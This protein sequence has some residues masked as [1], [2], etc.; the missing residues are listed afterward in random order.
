MFD[1]KVFSLLVVLLIKSQTHGAPIENMLT[2]V[3]IFDRDPDT[4]TQELPD[5]TKRIKIP[6]ISENDAEALLGNLG[7][8][9]TESTD[10]F[11]VSTRFSFG[12]GISLEEMFRNYQRSVGLNETGKLDDDTK[13]SMAAPRC[14]TRNLAKRGDDSKWNKRLITYRIRDYPAG[15]SPTSVQNLLKRAFN[16]WSKV[17]NLD[18]L[19]TKEREA[20]IEVNFGGTS[21]SRRDRR[22]SFDSPTIM[23]HAY[24]PE[25]GDLHFNSKYFFDNVEYLEDFLDTAMHEIGHSL[26]LEHTNTKGALM[27]PTDMNRYTKP[28]PDDVRRIQKLYGARRGGRAIEDNAAPRLCTVKKYD[29]IVDD[30]SGEWFILSGKYY[31]QPE[32]SNPTGK[33]ISS[34]WPGLTGDIDAAFRY[35]DGRTYFFKGDRFWRYRGSRLEVGYP[36]K[37]S[38]GFPGLPNSIDAAFVDSKSKIFAVKHNTYWVY[39]SDADSTPSFRISSLG[40]PSNVDAAINTGKSFIAFKGKHFYRFQNGKFTEFVNKW[41]IC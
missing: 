35:P 33:L 24:F 3:L 14:G 13:L 25:D 6:A 29:A 22:C 11:G 39:D 8:N 40:L 16:E 9:E 34:K 28:Q 21:H 7:F 5:P 32:S 26:G 41:M 15:A 1:S 17:T 4:G 19:E 2:D 37:I 12:Q 31:F 10:E 38:E 30:I 27:H 36:R 18:F 23:A 20:D